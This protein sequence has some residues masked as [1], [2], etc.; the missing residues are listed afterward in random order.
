MNQGGAPQQWSQQEQQAFDVMG[1]MPQEDLSN[2]LDFD[3]IDEMDFA[4]QD[5]SSV[6][7][8]AHDMQLQ[9]A[10]HLQPHHLHTQQRSQAPDNHI[11]MT[12]APDFSGL[13]LD[14]FSQLQPMPNQLPEFQQQQQLQ[15]QDVNQMMGTPSAMDF[16]HQSQQFQRD[17]NQYSM[18]VQNFQTHYSVPPTPNSTDVFPGSAHFPPQNGHQLMYPGHQLHP[19]KHD[20]VRPTRQQCIHTMLMVQVRWEC[21]HLLSHHRY[22]EDNS[23]W[24]F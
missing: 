1:G 5:F 23:P 21:S 11:Q 8:P 6:N 20:T 17:P 14:D 9:D 19:G 3:N 16:A 12:D 10:Q 24:I 4:L 18:P 13:D 15:Q 2:F 7:P 22:L